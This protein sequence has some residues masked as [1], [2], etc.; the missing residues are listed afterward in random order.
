[1]KKIVNI[2]ILIVV[3]FLPTMVDAKAFFTFDNV[4]ERHLFL[5]YEDSKYY[6]LDSHISNP[7]T[8]GSLL[9]FDSNNDL[10]SEE[11]LFGEDESENFVINQNVLEYYRYMFHL[12]NYGVTIE[13]IENDYFYVVYYYDENIMIANL[14]DGS[15]SEVSFN[16]DLNVTKR[17]LGK[18]YDVYKILTDRGLYVNY[19]TE[20]DGYF[21]V[22]YHDDTDGNDYTSVF[23]YECNEI[24]KYEVFYALDVNIYIH[25]KIIYVMEN[26]K[27]LELFK[28]DG[29]KIQTL[30]ISHE[31]IDENMSSEY[32]TDIDPM[33]LKVVNNDLFI[34]YVPSEDGCRKRLSINDVTD[35]AKTIAYNPFFTLKYN[36]EFD[37]NTVNSSSGDFTYE[38]KLD[39]DGRSY[40]ELKVV[41]K[42][43]YSVEEIIVTDINGERIEVT[44]NKFYK[45]ANDVKIEV[46]YVQ[47]EYIPIPDTFLSKSLTLI[48][49]G[50]IL[51]G[52][53][54]YTIN[55]VRGESKVDI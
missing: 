42:N 2:L 31:L 17:I 26:S 5:N 21:V 49:I 37:I 53:G 10:V 24:V 51:V 46:K 50:L 15:S 4:F 36:L 11:A 45:P 16:D 19:I 43:G 1:M 12:N 55:Y 54:I 35:Y 23:D 33:V 9:S 40:V 52:L 22:N 44:D 39:E 32:C 34:V 13:D 30:N 29:T 7:T 28:L 38:E 6:F 14:N 47:G 48:I 27:K 25:D 20:Y 41:P 3:C 18:S 8:V